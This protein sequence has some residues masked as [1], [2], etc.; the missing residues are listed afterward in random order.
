MAFDDSSGRPLRKTSYLS[1]D[2]TP[3]D[4]LAAEIARAAHNP[5][6]TA[7]LDASGTAAAVL[8]RNRQAVAVN[9]EY[10]K[11]AGVDGPASALGLR[12]G[13][14]VGCAYHDDGP[15]GC[16]AGRACP[17]CG[18][19]IALLV[20]MHRGRANERTCALER[21]RDGVSSDLM[22]RVRV[23][24]VELDGEPFLLLAL[25][26]VTAENQRDALARVFLHDL[27]NV[28]VGLQAA[29]ARLDG[30][31]RDPSAVEDVRFLS[32]FLVRE[33]A[34][35]RALCGGVADLR[36]APRRIEID[37]LLEKVRRAVQRHPAAETRRI[38]VS[39][40][41]ARTIVWSDPTL[42]QHVLHNMAINALEA[43]ARGEAIRIT[44][45]ERLGRVSFRVWNAGAIPAAVAPRIFQRH[46]ST[47]PG[48]GRGHG[49]YAMK[50]FG[51]QVIGGQVTFTSSAAEGTSFRMSLPVEATARA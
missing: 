19:A 40:T 20:A 3:A 14:A 6:L 51:E 49:T 13:E 1:P 27:A 43:T 28:A 16:G 7:L 18:A 26:D 9:L 36:T 47:K 23:V 32:E 45:E 44:V 29:T 10:L 11:V 38:E 4:V 25:R 12:P 35:Q 15:G 42:L 34:V 5:L 41:A 31:R 30:P 2:R 48:P 37:D 33:V 24:P 17:T 39:R 21:R 46:F 8:D 22:L 50:L